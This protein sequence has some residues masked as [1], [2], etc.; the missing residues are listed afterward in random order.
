MRRAFTLIEVLVV[1][2]VIA[3]LAAIVFPVFATA[4]ESA[5]RTSCASNL[6][7]LGMA[8][9]LYVQ[10]YDGHYFQHDW[11]NPQYWFGRV[12]GSTVD[13]SQGLLYPYLKN[14]EVQKCPSF[15]GGFEYDGATAGYGYNYGY[16][17]QNWGT[18]GVSEAQITRAANCIVF[19]DAALYKF[20][21]SPPA[22]H[23]AFGL[24]PPSVTLQWNS[25]TSQFRHNGQTNVIFA[26]G[27]VKSLPPRVLSTDPPLVRAHLH[28][29]DRTDDE[30][31]TGR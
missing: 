1:I 12:N 7:Q 14:G 13:R 9:Q 3:I 23:E 6:R 25:P 26:D 29:L 8:T 18:P 17:T 2:A 31:F 4:R 27:H 30:F 19:G 22:V 16:L 10:D 21:I 15:T 5:R 20:W 28:H 24:F 11:Q